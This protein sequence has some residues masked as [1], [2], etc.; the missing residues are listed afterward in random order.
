M[1]NA[2][3][4]REIAEERLY[5]RWLYRASRKTGEEPSADMKRQKLTAIKGAK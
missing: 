2:T 5:F 4:R 1:D 3:T